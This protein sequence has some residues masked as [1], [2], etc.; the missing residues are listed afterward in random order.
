MNN[1]YFKRFIKTEPVK[2]K[3]NNVWIYTR[4][5][6]KRQFDDNN[7]LE[8]QITTAKKLAVKRNYKITNEFGNTYESAKNDFTRKEFVKLINEVKKSQQKPFAIMIYKMSRFSR[9]GGSAIGLV[10]DL[11]KNQ[12]VHLIEVSTEL[13]T[14]TEEGE[15]QIHYSLINARKENMERLTYTLPGLKHFIKSGNWLGR[16]PRGYDHYGPKVKDPKF[17]QGCQEL[18]INDD[19]KLLKMAW[20]WKLQ[21]IQDFQIRQKLS[22]RGLRINKQTLSA[23]WRNPFYCGI[24]KNTFLEGEVVEGNWKGL[25]S[26]D[27]FKII[28]DRFDA[29]PKKEYKPYTAQIDRPLQNQLYCGCCGS[30]MTGYKAKGKYDYYKC[31]NTS[32]KTKDLSA[33]SS[34]KSIKE[35]I[36][37]LFQNLLTNFKLKEE[38]EDV[39]KEQMKL[40]L[41]EQSFKIYDDQTIL[42]KRLKELQTKKETLDSRFAFGEIDNELYNRFIGAVT[43]ELIEIEEKL[44]DFKIKISNL[45]KKVSELI[46]FS[47]N[48][49][50]IWV[51][52][53]YETKLS[54][55]KL[56]FPNGIVI[57]PE[58]RTYRTSNLNPIFGL[59]HSFTGGNDDANKKRTGRNTDPSCVVDNS[60]EISN[61]S[62]TPKDLIDTHHIMTLI[63]KS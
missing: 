16:A 43:S 22:I 3:N 17:V 30:K 33:N 58:D 35:G 14:T 50:N 36:H 5:S 40:T 55:Q 25:V 8:N 34:K 39:F 24:N 13:D 37:N 6:S 48:L 9:S 20:D 54:V 12:G 29:K 15:I 47:K 26:K 46:E 59:I 42:K 11:V 56:L 51:S 19:G 44:E 62:L 7:S 60:I 2:K 31:L 1:E 28:N 61:I 53:E 21:N 10:N 45:D 27:S 38:L 4:V 23:M 32:C 18:K 52:G 57:N 63:M 41:N 49:S